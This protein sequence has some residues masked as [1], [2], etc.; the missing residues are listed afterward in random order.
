VSPLGSKYGPLDAQQTR[1][2]AYYESIINGDVDERELEEVREWEENSRREFEESTSSSKKGSKRRKK[3]D[4][5]TISR[6]SIYG[7]RY[8]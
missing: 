7:Q 6:T 5:E 3:T 1:S 2:R 8:R 4:D